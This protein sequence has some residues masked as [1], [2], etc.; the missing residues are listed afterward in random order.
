MRGSLKLFTWFGIPVHLHWSFGLIF[1]Y[2]LWIGYANNLD[3]LGTIWLMGFFM[4][5]FGCVLLHEYGHALTARR[6]GVQTQ[7]IILTPI[8]GIA[9]LER[10]PEK[11]VQE[12]LVAIAGPMVNVVLA[13]G[14]FFL[15]KLLFQG[16]RWT[17]FSWILEQNLT[18]GDSTGEE[19]ADIL[20][21]SGIP[22]SGLLFYLP[23]LVVTNIALVVFNLIPA[24][25][26]DGGR[27]F[28]ALLAMRLGRVRATQIASW[29]GQGI[30]LLFIVFGLWQ[31]AITL[32]LIGLFVF[33]T[34]RSENSMVRL[35]AL[36]RGYKARDLLRPNFTRLAANDWMQTPITLVQQGLERHFLVFDLEDRL[37]GYLPEAQILAAMKKHD[38]SAEISQ[39]MRP[40]IKVIHQEQSLEYVYHLL[41]H[42][43]LGVVAVADQGTLVGVI[44][45][46]GLQNFLR[47][48]ASN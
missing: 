1:L 41:Q 3:M 17:L 18:F 9:R 14:L 36:L 47:M 21:E 28:R 37:V 46:L 22:S 26:M 30:A 40:D 39:Y 23:V 15:G 33:S 27:I 11:P 12:F 38:L 20:D 45:Q 32:A 6:Y 7:D 24:F 4:A 35:D 5:L 25:P 19:A 10:M 2:A 8:G 48:R 13:I 43:G 34:A 31:G 29:L 44:D 42:Q 16:D